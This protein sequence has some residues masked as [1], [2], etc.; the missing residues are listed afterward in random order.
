MFRTAANRSL[1]SPAGLL[2]TLGGAPLSTSSALSYEFIKTEKKGEKQN[3]GLVQLNRP[4]ALNA[5][6]D[7]LMTEVG[8]AMKDFDADPSVGAIV[9]T[10]SEK[11]FA[12]GADIAEMQKL[13]YMDC[14]MRNFLSEF[15]NMMQ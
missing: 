8:E 7:E 11:A 12:A 10:G 2:R 14:Y 15:C 4:R 3:V 13:T 5:L 9:L 1:L 6:C